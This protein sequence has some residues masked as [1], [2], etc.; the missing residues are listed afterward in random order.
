MRCGRKSG[1]GTPGGVRLRARPR[2]P[3]WQARPAA[4]RVPQPR[5]APTLWPTCCANPL[6]QRASLLA[7]TASDVRATWRPVCVSR[8]FHRVTQ[9]SKPRDGLSGRYHASLRPAQRQSPPDPSPGSSHAPASAPR[10]SWVKDFRAGSSHRNA[11][12]RQQKRRAALASS[13][14]T[15]HNGMWCPVLAA[16]HWSRYGAPGEQQHLPDWSSPRQQRTALRRLVQ[17]Y[18]DRR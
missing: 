18:D 9:R 5:A 16:I 8:A 11:A 14:A 6:A 17:R 13:K 10:E 15:A 1:C 3:S 4:D 12:R 2:R 7:G